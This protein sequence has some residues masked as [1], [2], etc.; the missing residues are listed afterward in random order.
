MKTHVSRR[1][2]TSIMR[3]RQHRDDRAAVLMKTHVSR[4]L[5]T[6]HHAASSAPTACASHQSVS[7]QTRGAMVLCHGTG[8]VMAPAVSWHELCHGTSC[9]MTVVSWHQLCHDTSSVMAPAV[10]WHQLCHDST[11]LTWCTNWYILY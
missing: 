2:E 5:E 8:C 10:S 11:C 4:R 9:V 1:L 7:R 6:V 3:Y